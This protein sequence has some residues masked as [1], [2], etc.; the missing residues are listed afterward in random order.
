[1]HCTQMLLDVVFPADAVLLGSQVD[2][3]HVERF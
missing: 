3:E 2:D 1:V